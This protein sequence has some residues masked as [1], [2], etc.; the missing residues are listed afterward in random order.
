MSSSIFESGSDPLATLA[1]QDTAG[2]RA[3]IAQYTILRA[4]TY[5]QSNKNEEALKEFRKALAFDPQNTTAQTYIGKINLALGNT[6]EAI[7]AFKT[8]ASA[9]PT[10][11]DAQVNLANAYLQDKQYVESEKSFKAAA[12]LDPQNPL[13]DYT[14]GH[15]YAN[16]GR[17][18]EAESQFLKVQKISPNDGNVYYSLGLVANKLGNYEAATENLEKAISLKKTFPAA[19]YELGVA[20][21]GLGRTDDAQKQLSALYTSNYNLATD[22]KFLLDKPQMIA[23][24]VPTNSGFPVVFG[25]NTPL[26]MLDPVNMSTPDAG[27]EFSVSF[28]FTNE[29]NFASVT[30]VQNWSISRA[31]STEAGYYNNTMPLTTKEAYL[32]SNPLSVRYNNITREATI[33]FRLN[34]NATGDAVIDPSHVVFSFK[35]KDAAGRDMDISAN[36]MDGY[37][38]DPF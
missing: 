33:S 8:M 14:L 7:K 19:N 17:L 3:Q 20:Y 29:M 38:I 16:T 27:K 2:Q 23:M 35:G 37:S 31:N 18:A 5:L 24:G 34:Q 26:W 21:N 9:D 6:Y 28:L 25:A 32:P 15:Q 11:I 10:S 36:E 1:A 4:A 12:R 13:A 22:L 30:N